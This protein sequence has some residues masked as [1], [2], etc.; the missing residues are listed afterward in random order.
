MTDTVVEEI[1]EIVEDTAREMQ[2][3]SGRRVLLT[4]YAIGMACGVVTGYFI[5]NR[6][7]QTKYQQLEMETRE[8][9]R[10]IRDHYHNKEKAA[11][12]KRPLEEMV[13]TLGYVNS[14]AVEEKSLVVEV[15]PPEVAV[16][17]FT[18][19]QSEEGWDYER[20]MDK[21]SP[22]TPYIIH[23][24]EF[25]E[26]VP[27]HTQITVTW[28]SGDDV[29][30]DEADRPIP[31][32]EDRMG[33]ANLEKMGYGSGDPNVLY[34]RSER[35]GIDYEILLTQASYEVEVLGYDDSDLSHSDER[36]RRSRRF[37]DD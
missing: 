20:E 35:F 12:V 7:W 37:D 9:I 8:E 23:K 19:T 15:P 1:A 5:A 25:M 21:R 14:E 31:D 10:K 17:V 34:V 26:N 22:D 16:N 2:F 27:E 18:Q 33:V 13:E 36:S 3:V 28:Y 4:G 24:D 29:I 30:A 32:V 6:R 11:Q